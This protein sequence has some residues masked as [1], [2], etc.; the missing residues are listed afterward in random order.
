MKCEA[1]ISWP[2]SVVTVVLMGSLNLDDDPF[3]L[4]S[5]SGMQ[6]SHSC[7]HYTRFS[8]GGVVTCEKSHIDAVLY[9]PNP[10]LDM[11]SSSIHSLGW[12]K[13]ILI[14]LQSDVEVEHLGQSQTRRLRP[15]SRRLA[16]QL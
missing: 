7:L 12:S 1:A 6:F 2:L 4:P 14:V 8:S 11:L 9:T 3:F 5:I 16:G 10:S 15:D 13:D